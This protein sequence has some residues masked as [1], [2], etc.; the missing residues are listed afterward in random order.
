MVQHSEKSQ[1]IIQPMVQHSATN[2]IMIQPMV[3]HSATTQIIIQPMVQH[4]AMSQSSLFWNNTGKVTTAV[5]NPDCKLAPL[6]HKSK[7]ASQ[8][9]TLH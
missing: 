9:V 7:S 3:Q 4:S 8:S 1:I 6:T 2:Q 5:Q